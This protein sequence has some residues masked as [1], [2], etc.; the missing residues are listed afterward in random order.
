GIDTVI[1]RLDGDDPRTTIEHLARHVLPP[2][3]DLGRPDRRSVEQPMRPR[4]DH[5][6]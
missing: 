3:E 6:S 2:V 4:E 1:G 5:A